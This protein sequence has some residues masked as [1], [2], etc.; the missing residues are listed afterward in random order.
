M[1]EGEKVNREEPISHTQF[2]IMSIILNIIIPISNFK[3]ASCL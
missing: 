3:L 1:L 2:E